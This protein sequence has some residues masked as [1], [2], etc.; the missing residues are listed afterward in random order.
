MFGDSRTYDA[1]GPTFT[2]APPCALPTRITSPNG[3]MDLTY[4]CAGVKRQGDVIDVSSWGSDTYRDSASGDGEPTGGWTYRFVLRDHL[5]ATRVVLADRFFDG[6]DFTYPTSL[7]GTFGAV[8][9]VNEPELIEVA[10]HYPFGLEHDLQRG[11]LGVD[12]R[13]GYTGQELERALELRWMDY[14]AR[15]YDPGLGRFG[16]V[17]PLASEFAGWTPY[18]YV[19]NNPISLIDPSGMSAG[20]ADDY[21]MFNSYGTGN[22]QHMLNNL[23]RPNYIG[24]N[25]MGDGVENEYVRDRNTGELRKISDVGGDEFDFIYDGEVNDDGSVSIDPSSLKVKAVAEKF[26]SDPTALSQRS[27]PTPGFQEVS[28]DYT[29]YNEWAMANPL[30][31][32]AGFKAGLQAVGVGAGVH[33]F[34]TRAKPNPRIAMVT[35]TV[36]SWITQAKNMTAYQNSL[37]HRE[38]RA[39]AASGDRA[40]QALKSY[41][42]DEEGRH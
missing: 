8:P 38:K 25:E 15:W 12:Y 26:V 21:G 9:Q 39:K 4:T 18:H 14:G 20:P 11:P 5:N 41:Y 19:H 34:V 27:N 32:P 6:R 3:T 1:P 23:D 40:R 37:T 2:R 35:F 28:S 36:T 10:D 16:Q 7:S 29:S 17:D 30:S 31:D 24:S 22:F 42:G 33:G 13:F